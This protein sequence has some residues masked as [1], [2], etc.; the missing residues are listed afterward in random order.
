MPLI[1]CSP[2]QAVVVVDDPYNDK[3]VAGLSFQGTPG[4]TNIVDA[5]GKPYNNHGVVLSSANSKFGGTSAYFDGASYM[6]TP[7]APELIFENQNWTIDFWFSPN[8]VTTQY[9]EII[10]K[11]AGLQIYLQYDKIMLAL[12]SNNTTSYFIIGAFGTLT[13]ANWFHIAVQRSGN[14]YTGYL[15]GVGVVLGVTAVSSDTG[16]SPL[17][18]GSYLTG[19][20]PILG[21]MNNFRVTKGVARYSGNFTVPT[22]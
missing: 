10:T 14:T 20:Y 4:S 13:T 22:S 11:G 6:E 7:S 18:V 1:I 8:S 2:Y 21:Y 9:Q 19:Y 15:N 12:S 5:N 3:V 17:V 16:V